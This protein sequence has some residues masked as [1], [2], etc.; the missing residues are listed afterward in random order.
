MMR[1]FRIASLS[2]SPEMSITRPRQ[3]PAMARSGGL[4]KLRTFWVKE[5][6]RPPGMADC[7]VN[8]FAAGAI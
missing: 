8:S 7:Y 4:D 1:I 6:F 2:L 3:R 5:R